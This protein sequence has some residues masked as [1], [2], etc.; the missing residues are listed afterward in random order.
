MLRYKFVTKHNHIDAVSRE[1]A[2]QEYVK[3]LTITEE[4][5][6]TKAILLCSVTPSPGPNNMYAAHAYLDNELIAQVEAPSPERAL[7]ALG[8]N[9]PTAHTCRT[10]QSRFGTLWELRLK[11]AT[12]P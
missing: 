4:K 7:R 6:P 2:L 3:Q 10:Y 1:L 9:N 5:I 11:S 12:T 8:Y